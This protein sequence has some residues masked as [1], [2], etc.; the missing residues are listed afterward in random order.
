MGSEE[1]AARRDEGS[2]V[3]GSIAPLVCEFFGTFL[4]QFFAGCAV[5][6]VSSLSSAALAI[7]FTLMV[8][9]PHRRHFPSAN[10]SYR[11][12]PPH[13]RP[14]FLQDRS[15]SAFD[16]AGREQHSVPNEPAVAS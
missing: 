2:S 8:S 14:V 9:P 4:F 1:E 12:Q 10:V 7:G 11:S 6:G 3:A 16:C 5:V 15:F 13:L